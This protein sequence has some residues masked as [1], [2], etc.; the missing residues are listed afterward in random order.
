VIRA[1][2]DTNVYVAAVLSRNGAP[3]RLVNALAEGLYD[4]VTC[5]LLLEELEAVLSR[6]KIASRVTAETAREY[7]SW[8]GRVTL[9]EADPTNVPRV[10]AD[11][12]DD[13]L[14]ALAATAAARVI[15]SGD[16][17]LLDLAEGK[18]RAMSPAA[19]A[20]LVESLR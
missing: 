15:V 12:N 8:L 19:F 16:A 11:P 13:Y 7:C 20:Q 14:V 17:H 18:T 1:V 2:L 3:A 6:P 5:P 4:A 10:C 9:V